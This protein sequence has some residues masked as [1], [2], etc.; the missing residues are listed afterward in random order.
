MFNSG[1]L[2]M[3]IFIPFKSGVI[4]KA[5]P[6]IVTV[7]ASLSVMHIKVVLVALFHLSVAT[8]NLLVIG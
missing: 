2:E 6:V 3:L 4:L 1:I 7:F 5:Q 8:E